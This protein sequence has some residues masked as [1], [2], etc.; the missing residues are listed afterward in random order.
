MPLQ[1]GE[2]YADGRCG[3][4][5]NQ[6]RADKFIKMSA[7]KGAALG[8]EGWGLRL[9]KK[10]DYRCALAWLEKSDT[11]NEDDFFEELNEK[12]AKQK[13]KTTYEIKKKKN[14][15]FY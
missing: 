1:V 13:E 7:E 11:F 3:V 14:I 4:K 12:I 5:P 6:S 10:G 15:Q 8:V 2:I 9:Y